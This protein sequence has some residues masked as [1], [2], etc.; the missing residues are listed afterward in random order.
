MN[1]SHFCILFPNFFKSNEQIYRV[2]HENDKNLMKE[3]QN[4]I[5]FQK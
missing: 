4:R 3:G 2:Y 5:I 1:L